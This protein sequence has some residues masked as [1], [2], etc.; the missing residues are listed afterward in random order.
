VSLIQD[1]LKKVQDERNK[2]QRHEEHK[3]KN[4]ESIIE[5]KAN[6]NTK[7]YMVIGGSLLLLIIVSVSVTFLLKKPVKINRNNFIKIDKVVKNKQKQKKTL[8]L[9]K[10]AKIVQE[11]KN[12]SIKNIPKQPE[13][14]DIIIKQDAQIKKQSVTSKALE[15]NA[16]TIFPVFKQKVQLV[17]NKVKKPK[18]KKISKF[19]ELS[20]RGKALYKQKQFNE[21]AL[22]FIEAL[23]IK[24]SR[25]LY[26]NIY[27][28]YKRSNNIILL[29]A[30]AIEALSQFKDNIFFN[31][32]MGILLFRER[33]YQDALKY[34]S[35]IQNNMDTDVLTYKGLCHFHLKD[36]D[37]SLLIFKTILNLDKNKVESYYYIGL[38]YD[39]LKNY[40][41]ALYNY[42]IFEKLF[43]NQKTKSN[44]RHHNWVRR[45][46]DILKNRVNQ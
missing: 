9:I 42:K 18:V 39:N 23:K 26:L 13:K 46:I 5:S 32:V 16:K 17:S 38:I 1:A 36:F 27:K 12:K 25:V 8:N 40:N 19:E 20:I 14:K 6:P 30:Y 31:K 2:L 4:T 10:K 33:N 35:L 11:L 43:D 21:A 15:Q 22:L 24:K 41:D 37:K 3:G 29:K 34:F 28:C 7:R 45:R 44:F